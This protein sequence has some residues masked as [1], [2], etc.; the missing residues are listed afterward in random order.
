MHGVAMKF[1]DVCVKWNAHLL[2]MLLHLCAIYVRYYCQSSVCMEQEIENKHLEAM[3][4][5]RCF[6]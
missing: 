4:L 5:L 1:N 3:A 2:C 6:C